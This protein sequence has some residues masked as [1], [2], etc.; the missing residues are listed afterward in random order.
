M[1]RRDIISLCITAA[2]A[3]VSAIIL[4]A[5]RIENIGTFIVLLVLCVDMTCFPCSYLY[6]YDKYKNGE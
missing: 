2:L 4:A 3:V 1:G 5:I 6:H